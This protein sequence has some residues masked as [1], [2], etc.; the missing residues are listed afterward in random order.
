MVQMFFW[1][2][3]ENQDVVKLNKNKNIQFVTKEVIDHSLENQG[4]SVAPI[5]APRGVG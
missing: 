2:L 1:G 4:S 5:V 3:R